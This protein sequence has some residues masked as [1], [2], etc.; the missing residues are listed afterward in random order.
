L[1]DAPEILLVAGGKQDTN[2]EKLRWTV[3]SRAVD[4]LQPDVIYNDGLIRTSR[5]ASRTAGG[6]LGITPHAPQPGIG[7]RK[8]HIRWRRY[9]RDFSEA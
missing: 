6:K 5:V 9:T 1:A 7:I 3:R 8:A 4:I 2:C